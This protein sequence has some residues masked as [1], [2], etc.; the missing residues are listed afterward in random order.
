MIFYNNV[1]IN[2]F[3]CLVH[4]KYSNRERERERQIKIKLGRK[5]IGCRDKWDR[6]IEKD[7]ETD[8]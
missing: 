7:N 2:L 5:T 3:K 1:N 8:R 6:K 4:C